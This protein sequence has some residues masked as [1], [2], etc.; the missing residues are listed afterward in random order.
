MCNREDYLSWLLE[1]KHVLRIIQYIAIM[2]GRSRYAALR[3]DLVESGLVPN[4]TF[5]KRLNKM[6]EAGLLEKIKT[7][8]ASEYRLAGIVRKYALDYS[9]FEDR[10]RKA[11]GK[12]EEIEKLIDEACD[13]IASTLSEGVKAFLK[14]GY[15]P[16]AG[17]SLVMAESLY[18]E[19]VDL[20][21]EFV[22]SQQ[23]T[24][25]GSE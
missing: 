22:Q 21:E 8:Q 6:A 16:E 18:S 9:F 2:G 19:L 25:Y 10:L 24:S 3:K 7:G 11:D 23:A 20:I 13:E 17:A 14:T 5:H 15:Y 1:D 4:A 12:I